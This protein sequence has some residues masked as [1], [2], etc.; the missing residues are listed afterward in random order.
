[1]APIP[2]TVKSSLDFVK[3]LY[4]KP[5]DKI[6]N[7]RLHII[8]GQL[9]IERGKTTLKANVSSRDL[10]G[11]PHF[12][13]TPEFRFFLNEREYVIPEGESIISS[14]ISFVPDDNEEAIFTL[15]KFE[16]STIDWSVPL[17]LRS[18]QPLKKVS[19][20]H[21]FS[22]FG[23]NENNHWSSELLEVDYKDGT[24]FHLYPYKYNNQEWLV[25][26]ALNPVEFEDFNEKAFAL[27]VSLGLFTDEIALE[28]AFVLASESPSFELISGIRYQQLRDSI[29]GQY[30]IFTTNP[31][32]IN[33]TL[34]KANN[35][36]A[37]E[38]IAPD[39]KINRGLIDWLYM[40]FFSNLVN[41]IYEHEPL[42]RASVLLLEASKIPLEF[43]SGL[44]AVALECL[45]T[46]LQKEKGEKGN[47]PIHKITYND[48]IKPSLK[49]VL[50]DA[51]DRNLISEDALNI[52][53]SRLDNL[54][55]ESN[56]DKLGARFAEYGYNLSD[57][58]KKAI[59]NRN[60]LLHGGIL[61]P[62][63]YK[64]QVDELFHCSIRL[65]KLCSILLLNRVGFK[66]Y[67]L[68]L[69]VLYGFKEEC[70][71]KQ[72]VLIKINN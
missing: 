50:K 32:W 9:S 64:E 38:Q 35:S 18:I 53:I 48:K 10:W 25:I 23:Y 46:F 52:M 42:R 20:Y 24:R 22:T 29:K 3:S 14:P 71:A 27:Q 36:Y 8:D 45:T 56:S 4:E 44:Y 6:T 26:E 65:H 40:D 66:S 37:R 2:K 19:W 49:N 13:V 60:R 11:L 15:Q 1:M 62:N 59:S 33:E 31:Y 34:N 28:E 55:G 57:I 51:L 54:N 63:N 72:P 70:E 21:T 12:E 68:N 69:P 30:P 41:E 43:Q 58:D 47:P 67:M 7:P 5:L 39:G 16:D 17:F 61:G